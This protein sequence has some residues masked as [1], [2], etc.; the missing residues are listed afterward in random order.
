LVNRVSGETETVV[1][2]ANP[3]RADNLTLFPANAELLS[4]APEVVPN[5]NAAA[6]IRNAEI[7]RMAAVLLREIVEFILFFTSKLHERLGLNDQ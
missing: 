7:V 1:P 2:A 6:H 3:L 5:W 4:A